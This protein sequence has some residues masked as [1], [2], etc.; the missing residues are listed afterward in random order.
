MPEIMTRDQLCAFL[1]ISD[2]T[3]QRLERTNPDFPA[4]ISITSRRVGYLKADVER[5][6]ELQI[7]AAYARRTVSVS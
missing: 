1:N 2:T 5:W 6:F 7:T 3:R 4:K